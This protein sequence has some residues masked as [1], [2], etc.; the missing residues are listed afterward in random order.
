MKKLLFC[1]VLLAT[2]FYQLVEAAPV[3]SAELVWHD[4]TRGRDMPV[5]LYFPASDAEGPFPVI[6]FS[7]GLG[8]SREGYRYLGE[9]W[10]AHGYVSVHLQHIGSDEAL[11]R[12]QPRAEILRRMRAAVLNPSNLVDR[13]LDVRYAL[14][15][16][17][18]LARLPGS[19]WGRRLDLA[20]VGIA[21]HSF[22]AYTV[23]AVAGQRV[24]T[25][26]REELSRLG[27]DP[28]VKAALA[29]SSQR[30]FR[31]DLDAVYAPITIPIF[32]MTGTADGSGSFSAHGNDL[33]IGNSTPADRRVAYDHTRHARAA[34]LTFTGGDHMVFSGQRRRGDGAHDAEFHALILRASTAFWDAEI[35]GDAAARHWLEDG[36]FAAELGALGTFER[37]TPPR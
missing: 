15:E 36:G 12:G 18:R 26:R 22:G 7:H 19:E 27:P 9:Y 20:R 33:G 21:G 6:V 13:P 28:R 2:G 23:L 30:P 34:L 31:G 10:A 3:A 37:K 8:G 29:M 14:D 32:H 5:K 17:E 24:G 11:W 1:A 16:L 25:G 35:K 4:S